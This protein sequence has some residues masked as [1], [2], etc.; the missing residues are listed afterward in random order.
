MAK[1]DE[2]M[3]R[4]GRL[5]LREPRLVE[6]FHAF[7]T[8]C[9]DVADMTLEIPGLVVGDLIAGR[10][11]KTTFCGRALDVELHTF[12]TEKK[13]P[14]GAIQIFHSVGINASE[15]PLLGTCIFGTNSTIIQSTFPMEE[16][17]ANSNSITIYPGA[18]VFFLGS[19]C[20]AVSAGPASPGFPAAEVG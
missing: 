1:V 20:K 11:F 4:L 2:M 9:H 5:A 17:V 12:I 18:Y 7:W 6:H 14:L 16:D 13:E 19:L 3:D 10:S 15:R 8:C